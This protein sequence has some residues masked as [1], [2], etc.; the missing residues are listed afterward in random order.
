MSAFTEK[1]KVD[2]LSDVVGINTVNDTQQITNY[3]LPKNTLL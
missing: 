2:I 1:E 3:Y